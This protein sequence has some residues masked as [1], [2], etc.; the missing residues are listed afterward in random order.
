MLSLVLLDH[1]KENSDNC[2]LR[3]SFQ[4][5][6]ANFLAQTEALMRG[7]TADEARKELEAS[8]MAKATLEH[9]LP[10]KVRIQDGCCIVTS[11]SDVIS[12]C[13]AGV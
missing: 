13:V 7:K 12:Y 4:I 6:L 10:H 11:C 5:L 2:R 8:G 3:A 1:F 9:I